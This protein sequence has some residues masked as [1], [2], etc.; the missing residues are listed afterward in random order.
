MT[1]NINATGKVEISKEANYS[2]KI[3][4]KSIS[5]ENGANFNAS[6]KLGQVP[7]QTGALKER[8]PEKPL[9]ELV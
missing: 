7:P 2:G 3:T 4:S 5:V 1:G 6:V 9:T 8:P